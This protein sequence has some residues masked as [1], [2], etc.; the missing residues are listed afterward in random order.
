[1]V[2]LLLV[3]RRFELAQLDREDVD[4]ETGRVLVR[5]GKG[6][7]AAATSLCVTQNDC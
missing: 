2:T 4:S 6:G 1:M 5:C 7:K 3:T